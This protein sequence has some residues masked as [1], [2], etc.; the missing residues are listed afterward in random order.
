MDA[1]IDHPIQVAFGQKFFQYYF[2]KSRPSKANQEGQ[3][4]GPKFF[5]GVMNGL[6]FSKVKSKLKSISE[7]YADPTGCQSLTENEEL[8]SGGTHFDRMMKLF[9]A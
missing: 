1:P 4:V 2:S 9:T 8:T 5:S 3:Y 6:H 7:F